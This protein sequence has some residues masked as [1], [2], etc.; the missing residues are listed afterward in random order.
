VTPYQLPDLPFG[1]HALE[2]W[3][4]AETVHLHHDK[5]H[6]A[7]VDGANEAR[8]A[9]ADCDPSDK[10]RFAG[11]TLA[12]EFNLA[13][14]VLHTLFWD[15][16]SPDGVK[17]DDTL[18]ARIKEDFG[19]VDTLTK[20]LTA[21]C[22]AVQGSGWAAIAYDPMSNSLIVDTLHDH[23]RELVPN[24]TLLGVIDM[25]EHAYYLT[26]RNDKATW[27]KAAVEHINWTN[28]AHRFNDVAGAMARRH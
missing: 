14:H 23:H 5:H 13:G 3:C 10:H 7:Y 22:M 19:S 16:L 28:V 11:I 18:T 4:S 8:D 27:A 20:R 12:L 1:Y 17:P 2:P 15:S 26:H 9:L 25:W 21:A 24:T 6:R